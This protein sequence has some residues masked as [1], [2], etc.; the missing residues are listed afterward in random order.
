MSEFGK[1]VRNEEVRPMEA[2]AYYD[3]GRPIPESRQRQM[4]K[5]NEIGEA[6]RKQ[7]DRRMLLSMVDRLE[8]MSIEARYLKLTNS[9]EE[10]VQYIIDSALKAITEFSK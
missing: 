4:C 1:K 5:M 9:N 10:D 6:R 7:S 3:N 2:P 8:V